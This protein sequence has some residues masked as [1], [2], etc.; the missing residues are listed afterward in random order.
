MIGPILWASGVGAVMLLALLVEYPRFRAWWQVRQPDFRWADLDPGSSARQ[1]VGPLHEFWLGGYVRSSIGVPQRSLTMCV[2]D[3]ETLAV[4][5]PRVGGLDVRV[6]VREG[7]HEF[8]VRRGAIR[9][10]F[11]EPRAGLRLMGRPSEIRRLAGVT[12]GA[13]WRCR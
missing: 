3:A 9:W 5:Q 1:R 10:S 4:C 12:C 2:V 7:D 11:E 8:T 13:G 6:Y